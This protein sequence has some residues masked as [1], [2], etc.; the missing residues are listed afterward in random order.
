MLFKFFK[1]WR[2]KI[3]FVEEELAFILRHSVALYPKKLKG[4]IGK[5]KSCAFPCPFFC[6]INKSAGSVVFFVQLFLVEL[7]PLAIQFLCLEE[8][9]YVGLMFGS[10]ALIQLIANPFIGPWTN[11]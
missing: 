1:S 2:I 4:R 7:F 8:N 3:I 9:L 6:S 11:K 10:K 5:Q